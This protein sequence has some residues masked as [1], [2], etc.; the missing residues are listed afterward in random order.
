[1]I[2]DQHQ[3][4]YPIDHNGYDYFPTVLDRKTLYISG[5][6]VTQTNDSRF[7]IVPPPGSTLLFSPQGYTPPFELPG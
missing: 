1:M 3:Q 2:A 4:R 5:Y 6:A 7:V